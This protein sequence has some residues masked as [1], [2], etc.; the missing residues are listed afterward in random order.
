MEVCAQL[1]HIKAGKLKAAIAMGVLPA[2]DAR[3]GSGFAL[4]GFSPEWIQK[5]LPLVGT[6]A[7]KNASFPKK[8]I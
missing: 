3:A 6:A 1:G 4:S 2:A 5:A 7:F 8:K